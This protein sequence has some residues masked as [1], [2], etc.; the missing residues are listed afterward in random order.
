MG[1]I[2]CGHCGG[3]HG[4]VREVRTCSVERPMADGSGLDS[5]VE[6]QEPSEGVDV[7]LP[8]GVGPP[9]LGRSLV[10]RSGEQVPP[11]W[12]EHQRF[13]VD[14][15]VVAAPAELAQVLADR[16][17]SR[18]GFVVE[19]QA[20]LPALPSVRI[21]LD[22][23][24]PGF[25]LGHDLLV[26]AVHSNSAQLIDGHV[27]WSLAGLAVAL[28][29]SAGGRADVVLAD[30]TEAWIDGGPLDPFVIDAPIVHAVNLEAGRA[31]ALGRTN[32]QADL[33]PDQLDA[34]AHTGGAARIIAPA[35][36]GKTRVLTERARHLITN[37]N[38]PS[39][40]LTLVAFNKRAQLEMVDRMSDLRQLRIRTLNAL[41]LAVIKGTD[42]FVR[43]TGQVQVSTIDERD[44]RRIVQSLVEFPRRANTDPAAVWIEALSAARLGLRS[45][46][47]V[48][49]E[50]AGDVD[51]FGDVF[52][53]Y[54]DR[55]QANRSVDFDE[56]IFLAI[57]GLLADPHARQV[58]QRQCRFLLVDEFQDL[59]PAHLL[60]VRL[61]SGPRADVFGVGDDDQTIY[62]FSGATPEWLI[63]YERFFPGAQSHALEVNYRCAPAVVGGAS[64][65]LGYN[66]VRV[67]KEIRPAPGRPADEQDLLTVI[68]SDPTAAAGD[69][70]Q[71]LLRQGVAPRDIAV[72][73]RVNV[74]LAVPQVALGLRGV[75][76]VG[77]VGPEV[78]ERTGVRGALGWL[79]LAADTQDLNAA[80]IA[81]T[82]RRPS[83]GMSRKVVE[84][85]SE[86]RTTDAI[87]KLARRLS[88][89]DA[90]KVDSWLTDLNRL[91]ALMSSGTST[92]EL[93]DVISDRIGL[94]DALSTLDQ[95]KGRVDR[96]THLD[97][98]AML[99]AMARLQPDAGLFE[100][101]LRQALSGP[102]AQPGEGVMVSTVHRVKG[103]EW[104]HVIVIGADAESFPHRLAEL[105]EE[106]RVFHVAITRS[107][108]STAVVAHA[109]RPSR[110]LAEMAGTASVETETP[111][112]ASA[113]FE[114][115]TRRKPRSLANESAD[116]LD[117]EAMPRFEAL[118]SWRLDRARADKIAPFIV[119]H[120][121]VLRAIATA[122]PGTLRELAEVKGIGA[123]KLENYGDGILGALNQE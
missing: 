18:Q 54:R 48:E 69:R 82:V 26:H 106:R 62:G 4:T 72:L 22:E 31:V 92:A 67:P 5:A 118:R 79:R 113:R 63:N 53:K 71:E 99:K 108:Q 94:G 100:Y 20:Q 45:A 70:V 81:D 9:E 111:S 17:R 47:E 122:N 46:A 107:S 68:S 102:V 13:V 90:A 29:S 50:F 51:G 115:S 28:G 32:P 85:M 16:W 88:D 37:V 95:S 73:A 27:V 101:W 83:R 66:N 8:V 110:F 58:A 80:D 55:L 103:L 3:V 120:D 21:P 15:A 33:A 123:A 11:E 76:V 64:K 42:G 24:G 41:A 12:A 19:L 104:P 114:A 30:G 59:T 121:K 117:A 57:E 39:S 14:E 97:D 23:C 60:F 86:H 43:P 84:W 105:A 44:V 109:D 2:N 7:Q 77:A 116:Q 25:V 10:I 61:L 38:V 87:A 75:P 34:V 112:T 74:T 56:Q 1:H 6:R 49:D 89:R 98:L 119:F 52:Q 40:A 36:S 93:L 91:S 78:L 96:S 65:L 35:G